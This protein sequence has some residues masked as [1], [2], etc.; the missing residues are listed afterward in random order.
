MKYSLLL[1][2]ILNIYIK[3]ISFFFQESLYAE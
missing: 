1:N 2:E 3:A